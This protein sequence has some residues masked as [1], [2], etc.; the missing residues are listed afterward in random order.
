[1]ERKEK[2]RYFV[3]FGSALLWTRKTLKSCFLFY[4]LMGAIP[5]ISGIFH[6]MEHSEIG[7]FIVGCV[8]FVLIVSLIVY[9]GLKGE[10]DEN[11][12][13]LLFNTAIGAMLMS[14]EFL[15]LAITTPML[16]E[17]SNINIWIILGIY[18]FS[19]VFINGLT[20]YLATREKS[21]IAQSKKS[22]TKKESKISAKLL[23][24]IIIFIIAVFTA[25]DYFFLSDMSK[26]NINIL[27]VA[28]ATGVSIIMLLGTTN[29]LKVYLV[30]KYLS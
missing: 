4:I 30:K 28:I 26:E 2:I 23:W 22:T 21:N 29:F 19:F 20:L 10:T 14:V 25:V 3:E 7:P 17:D 27:I 9:I 15:I 11:F 1:M 13:D 24:P 16:E 12:T 18:I 8:P 6:L 5:M